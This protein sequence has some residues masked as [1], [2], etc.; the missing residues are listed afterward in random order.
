MKTVVVSAITGSEDDSL[1]GAADYAA[2]HEEQV[3]LLQNAGVGWNAGFARFDAPFTLELFYGHGFAR[4]SGLGNEQ[5]ARFESHFP[6][7]ALGRQSH[8]PSAATLASLFH[9]L[10][11]FWEFPLHHGRVTSS[12]APRHRSSRN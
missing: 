8:E 1:A 4:Q 2:A 12:R 6:A 11:G 10:A 3:C 5:V 9:A 7:R